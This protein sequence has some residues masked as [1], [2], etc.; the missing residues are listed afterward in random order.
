MRKI[1]RNKLKLWLP[2]IIS[3]MIL[4]ILLFIPTGY[5][6]A[7]IYQGTDRTVGKV[8]ETD[9]SMLLSTGL[10]QSGEQVCMIKLTGGK[11][12]GLVVEA[13]NMLNGSLEQD[14]IF[15]VGD[16]ALVV[17]SF[18]EDEIKSVN[19]IDHFRIVKEILIVSIFVVLLIAFA[20]KAGIRALLSFA[21]TILTI[22]KV[23]I[24]GYLNGSNPVI[25]GIIITLGLTIIT[26]TLVYGFDLRA[27]S[28]V[29]GA[30]LG[31]LT[32]AILG[33]LFTDL[34]QIHGAVM[35]YSESLLYSG[36]MNL[37]LT[38]IFMASIFIGS[39]GAVM[40]LAVD[41]TSAVH[42]VVSNKPDISWKEAAISGIHVGKAAIGTQT[43]T[44]LLAYSGG[45]VALLMVFMAQGTP[46]SNILNYKHVAS[47]ILDTIVGSIGLVT[48]APFTAVT[49]GILLTMSRKAGNNQPSVT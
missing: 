32:T 30:V 29:S 36:Y 8:L 12:K 1:M 37:D 45:Y 10:I 21:V 7:V 3:L 18:K 16:K 31:T 42:E 2:V 35:A 6:D 46:V 47:E 40:D 34:F 48:V 44:L 39:A 20:G 25:V 28:A 24:P 14:K 5:E 11:F 17:I 13:I 41:I 19:M 22:W 23:L 38:K 43:T 4:V 27:L 26:V 9:N 33:I 49:S 15:A